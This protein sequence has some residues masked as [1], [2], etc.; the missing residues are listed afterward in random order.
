MARVRRSRQS[1]VDYLE[2]WL[3]ITERQGATTAADRLTNVFDEKLK[4]LADF[5]G[6]GAIREDLGPSIRTF[7]VGNYLII[8]RPTKGGIELLRVVHGARDLRK[9]FRQ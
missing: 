1:K 2:I 9:L 8:Y 3:Y 5:P 4:L 7:P 6:M